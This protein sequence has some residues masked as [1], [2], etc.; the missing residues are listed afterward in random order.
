MLAIGKCYGSTCAPCCDAELSSVAQQMDGEGGRRVLGI[1][2]AGSDAEEMRLL[3]LLLQEHA[4]GKS[5]SDGEARPAEMQAVDL[6]LGASLALG[7]ERG[8]S[9]ECTET[10]SKPRGDGDEIE[11]P[12][13]KEA[14]SDLALAAPSRSG[15]TTATACSSR[16]DQLSS[17]D[18]DDGD[19]IS[20]PDYLRPPSQ[21][22]CRQKGL[23]PIMDVE[24]FPGFLEVG[25]LTEEGVDVYAV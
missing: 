8:H 10:L 25:T 7:P 2:S 12:D 21:Q 6:L 23:V 18:A 14:F 1:G 3:A 13:P 4:L 17:A 5:A 24:R 15:A 22:V 19:D 20:Q 9:R 16:G 11:P